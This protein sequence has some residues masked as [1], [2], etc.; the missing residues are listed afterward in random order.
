MIKMPSLK[1][2]AFMCLGLLV[3]TVHADTNDD[4]L[5]NLLTDLAPYA[6]PTPSFPL[7]A[8]P[9]HVLFALHS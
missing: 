9:A 8:F 4:F 7:F 3:D 2:T 6:A 5:N 1:L